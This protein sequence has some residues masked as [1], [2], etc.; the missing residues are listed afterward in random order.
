MDI[1]ALSRPDRG[2]MTSTSAISLRG[3]LSRIRQDSIV[4]SDIC[5]AI[6]RQT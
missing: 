3:C 6:D 2:R 5:Q 1:V 4:Y